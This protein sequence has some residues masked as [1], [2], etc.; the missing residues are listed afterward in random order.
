M[1]RPGRG[2]VL[3]TSPG[4]G[5][6]LAHLPWIRAMPVLLL[7]ADRLSMGRPTPL[8]SFAPTVFI[9]HPWE[10]VLEAGGPVG[11]RSVEQPDGAQLSEATR[12]GTFPTRGGGSICSSR[13]GLSHGSQWQR[14]CTVPSS[15]Q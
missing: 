9:L 7:A 8:G 12:G 11:L 14:A 13:N 10:V 5:K 3:P 15:T 4:S 2:R 6:S 1:C